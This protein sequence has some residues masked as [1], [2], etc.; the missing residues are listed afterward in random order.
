MIPRGILAWQKNKKVEMT[1]PGSKNPY[2]VT[3]HDGQEKWTDDKPGDGRGGRREKRKENRKQQRPSVKDA[4]G[5]LSAAVKKYVSGDADKGSLSAAVDNVIVHLGREMARTTIRAYLKENGGG[6]GK[7]KEAHDAIRERMLAKLKYKEATMNRVAAIAERVASFGSRGYAQP[8]KDLMSEQ[9]YARFEA[10]AKRVHAELIRK[11]ESV[12]KGVVNEL[13]KLYPEA[14]IGWSKD[15]DRLWL[16]GMQVFTSG[17]VSP[18]EIRLQVNLHIGEYINSDSNPPLWLSARLPID[19][20]QNG[21]KIGNPESYGVYFRWGGEKRIASLSVRELAE[22]CNA[23]IQ[24]KEDVLRALS[25]E[26]FSE[27]ALTPEAVLKFLGKYRTWFDFEVEDNVVSG[28]TRE[29]G[30]V[31]DET[32]GDADIAEAKRLAVLV[33]QEFGSKVKV[34]VGTVDEWTN[35]DITIP[36][37]YMK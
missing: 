22:F 16:G 35:L 28:T 24:K 7:I 11:M 20:D 14:K 6:A 25:P 8:L 19:G 2:K 37:Q 31:G 32:P 9:A 36:K 34:T 13:S 18:L 23:A 27:N 10:D 3:Y 29:G 33:R 5:T 21:I 26:K 1:S 30:S 15:E 12:V 4:K 17:R